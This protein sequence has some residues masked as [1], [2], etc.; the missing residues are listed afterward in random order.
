METRIRELRKRKG[1]TLQELA[2]KIGTTPQTV[3]R[4]E[5]ANMTVSTDWLQKFATVFGVYPADLLKQQGKQKTQNLGTIGRDG[6]ARL[7]DM[8]KDADFHLDI[9]AENP[10]AIRLAEDIG[11]YQEGA[12]LIANRLQGNDLANAHGKDCLVALDQQHIL[13]RR[14]IL[15]RN[16][17]F[18]LVSY[19]MSDDVRYDQ[20]V[21][22]MARITMTISY[23]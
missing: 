8:D 14:V 6:I 2:A 4:L 18:T 10:V 21:N 13:L 1:L 9:P 3:Q 11:P 15:G 19:D 20:A 7:S 5:T 23:I 12:V 22:W 17:R 16:N